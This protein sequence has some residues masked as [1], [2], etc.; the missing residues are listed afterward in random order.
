[1]RFWDAS[2]IVPLIL[3][4]AG[5]ASP[6]S[7]R[8]GPMFVWWGT[9]VEAVSAMARRERDGAL[10]AQQ[11][12][13]CLSRLDELSA[14]W[15]EVSPADELRDLARRL[16][17]VHALKAADGLQLAAALKLAGDDPGGLEFVCRDSRLAE[18]AAHEGLKI[19]GE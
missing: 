13:V 18:A 12:E 5:D 3:Q 2:A 16:L 15:A 6:V 17:R 7:P 19:H 4:D 8:G 14:D 1:M 10:T 11:V 9:E